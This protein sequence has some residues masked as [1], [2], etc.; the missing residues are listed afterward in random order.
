MNIPF[1]LPDYFSVFQTEMMAIYRSAQWILTYRVPFTCISF[2]TDRAAVKTLSNVA[3]NL[4]SSR[5]AA[6]ASTFFLDDSVPHLSG[7]PDIVTFRESAWQT[8]WSEL[9]HFLRNP[10]QSTWECH[11]PR[12][13]WPSRGNS[14][15]TPTYPRSMRSPPPPLGS[16][17]PQWI[18]G[19]PTSYLDLVVTSSPS[20]RPCLQVTV[21]WVDTRKKCDS[22]LTTCAVDPDPLKK[23]FLS[24]LFQCSSLVRCRYRL[25]GSQTLVG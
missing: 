25:F 18:E 21:L 2:F 20:Q 8:N 22:H 19:A 4:G 10:V 14:R 15:E 13:N 16:L 24:T 5:N 7:S 6:A 12:S 1:Q 11:L 17:G 23:R 9:A 3:K